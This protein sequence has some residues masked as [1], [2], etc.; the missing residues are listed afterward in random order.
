LG[1]PALNKCGKR[2]PS[3]AKSA[4]FV[5]LTPA[6]QFGIAGAFSQGMMP[7]LMER[8]EQIH[9]P[10]CTREEAQELLEALRA[11]Y[12]SISLPNRSLVKTMVGQVARAQLMQEVE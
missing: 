5:F 6:I 9:G 4:I 1:T 7:Q 3:P 11:A 8:V 10:H 2:K 12:R